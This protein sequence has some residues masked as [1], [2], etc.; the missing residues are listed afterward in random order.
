M[1]TVLIIF[2]LV[3]KTRALL[4]CGA[5]LTDCRLVFAEKDSQMPTMTLG[6]DVRN[7]FP[8][9]NAQISEAVLTLMRRKAMRVRLR[10]IAV[11]TDAANVTRFIK[12]VQQVPC[13]V[14]V[15]RD[16]SRLPE[17]TF[18]KKICVPKREWK[19]MPQ[20]HVSAKKASFLTRKPLTCHA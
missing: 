7:K 11:Q 2:S 4:I 16:T 5:T 9:Q 8:R 18:A 14:D 6:R 3:G 17:P 20:E 19:R 12:A 10:L 13:H 1:K 15:Q